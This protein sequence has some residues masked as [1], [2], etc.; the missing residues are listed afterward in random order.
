MIVDHAP[1]HTRP[2]FDARFR[3]IV[4]WVVKAAR[5]TQVEALAG[6]GHSGLIVVGAAAYLLKIPVIAVRKKGQVPDSD[7][8]RYVNA[9]LR[10]EDELDYGFVDD[11]VDE[12][13]TFRH[14][15]H[16][17]TS[18][19]GSWARCGAVFLYNTEDYSR[20]Y[21]EARCPGIPVYIRV[22]RRLP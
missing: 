12:G 22:A 18:E 9:V 6:C 10:T 5:K 13:K 14:V 20:S 17:I 1:S 15:T 19:L 11:I 2:V 8:G 21:V 4:E 3:A 16:A 7:D